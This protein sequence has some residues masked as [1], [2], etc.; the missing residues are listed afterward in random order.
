M[1]KPEDRITCAICGTE[2]LQFAATLIRIQIHP[3]RAGGQAWRGN[4]LCCT[5]CVWSIKDAI[6]G[7]ETRWEAIVD[8]KPA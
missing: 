1:P 3:P 8:F 6:A 7:C 4:R 5:D 2:I